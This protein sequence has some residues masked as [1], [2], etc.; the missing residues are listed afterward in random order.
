[1]IHSAH[2]TA[3]RQFPANKFASF[4]LGAFFSERSGQ[5]ATDPSASR[6]IRCFRSSCLWL[7]GV[8]PIPLLQDSSRQINLPR[9]VL[10]QCCCPELVVSHLRD[11]GRTGVIPD[12]A[13]IEEIA[14]QLRVVVHAV[15]I[16]VPTA[17]THVVAAKLHPA[18]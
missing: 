6:T 11:R 9:S 2:P 17:L 13:H 5:Q 1:M 14:D 12:G 10:G 16:E 8:P 7:M 4:C 3:P 18:F 15:A